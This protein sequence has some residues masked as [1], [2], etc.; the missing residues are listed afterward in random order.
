M[1]GHRQANLSAPHSKPLP[2]VTSQLACN[3]CTLV[4]RGW[5][6]TSGAAYVFASILSITRTF[7]HRHAQ[8]AGCMH[9]DRIWVNSH[10]VVLHMWWGLVLPRS[11]WLY[12]TVG[13]ML[14]GALSW[15]PG[16]GSRGTY[17]CWVKYKGIRQLSHC[18]V[19]VCLLTG[20]TM[21]ATASNFVALHG[22]LHFGLL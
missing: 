13:V 12:S 9:A 4:T 18:Q 8:L 7:I 6:G 2:A 21:S 10:S 20:G 5:G 15:A 16:T 14:Q 3:D 19:N 17:C 22:C 11:G 1:L